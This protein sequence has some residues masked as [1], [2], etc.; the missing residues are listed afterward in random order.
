MYTYAYLELFKLVFSLNKQ[1]FQLF[2]FI[3]AIL[4]LLN[5][6]ER[7]KFQNSKILYLESLNYDKYYGTYFE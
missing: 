6:V 7:L 2:Q 3:R 5:H 1:I 4:R